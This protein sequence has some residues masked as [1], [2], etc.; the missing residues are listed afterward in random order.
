MKNKI[1]TSLILIGTAVLMTTDLSAQTFSLSQAEQLARTKYPLIKQKDLIEKS[2]KLNDN[3]LAKGYLPQVTFGMQASYQ[4]DVTEITIPNAPFVIEPLSKDQYKI[5][6]DVNQV[7]Y[8][9]GMIR[10]QRDLSKLQSKIEGQK[11]EVDLYKIKEKVDQLYCNILYTDAM[12]AQVNTVQSDIESGIKKVSAQLQNGVAFK[13][14]LNTLK[15]EQL[16]TEQ[17]SI[18]LISARK[19]MLEV[20]SILTDT[21]LDETTILMTP[22]VGK[23]NAK[24]IKRPEIDVFKSQIALSTK[25][26]D[27]VKSRL[28]PK[29]SVFAQGGYGRPGYNM[30]LNAFD[31]Y[32]LGGIRL[33]WALGNLY[34]AKN[35]KSLAKI[36]AQTV[37]VQEE[38]F[39]KN[40]NAQI[41]QQEITVEKLEKLIATDNQ[42]IELRTSVKNSASAQLEAGV[43]T[44]S[45]YL[46]EVNAED[47]SRQALKAHEIQLIQ[48]HIQLNLL[49]GNK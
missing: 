28:L 39:L 27:I 42:I 1:I 44:A 34:S 46:R 4:S 2:A 23:S 9:G 48:A 16:K 10:N 45:D 30:L 32:G 11:V 19:D 47:Q 21:T 29:A 49:T 38:T 36:N 18:E 14:S 22:E 5:N 25:Q 8:D 41:R 26:Q 6:M 20:L 17:R 40:T 12:I 24:E 31:W 33:N 43:I 13:S 7:I 37:G 3:N 35:D 15:A